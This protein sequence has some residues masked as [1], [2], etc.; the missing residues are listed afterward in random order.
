MTSPIPTILSFYNLIGC[1]TFRHT[2]RNTHTYRH[3]SNI[4]SLWF[5]TM[6]LYFIYFHSISFNHTSSSGLLYWNGS[7]V[8]NTRPTLS[9]QSQLVCYAYSKIL[10]MRIDTMK[11]VQFFDSVFAALDDILCLL[12]TKKTQFDFMRAFQSCLWIFSSSIIKKVKREAL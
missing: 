8:L 6:P 3:T 10:V 4:Y 12:G 1:Y 9:L 7:N 2:Q 5:H 11:K